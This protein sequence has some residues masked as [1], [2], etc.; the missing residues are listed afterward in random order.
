MVKEGAV[1]VS[2]DGLPI[3]DSQVMRLA[4]EY[5]SM[6]NIPV[7]NHAEDECLQNDGVMNLSLIHI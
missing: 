7:I 5:S 3:T 6:F 2:D 4:L 1:A